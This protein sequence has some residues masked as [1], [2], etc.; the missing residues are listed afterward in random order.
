MVGRRHGQQRRK[1]M[2]RFRVQMVM[3]ALRSNGEKSGMAKAVVTK[4]MLQQRSE[5]SNQTDPGGLQTIILLKTLVGLMF[6]LGHHPVKFRDKR[7]KAATF[8]LTFFCYI[9]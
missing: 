7:P 9:D 5:G 3:R 1:Q 4:L 8:M 6:L 2:D